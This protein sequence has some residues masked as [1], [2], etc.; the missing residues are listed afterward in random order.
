LTEPLEPS[1]DCAVCHYMLDLPRHRILWEDEFWI[2]GTLLDVPGWTMVMT[3]RHAEGIWSLN[4][5]EAIRF[6]PMMRNVAR[7]V[8][9]VT[10]AERIHYAAMGEHSLHY[11]N[12]VLP[13][14]AGEV[15]IWD[16]MDMV[17]R[18]RA[19]ADPLA[20]LEMEESIQQRLSQYR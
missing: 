11:H 20:A 19:L 4:D 13:R 17:A 3:K 14:L 18:A 2:C 15:P 12:A 9:D 1:R 6:G 8:K 16:S 5:D 10:G 7:V